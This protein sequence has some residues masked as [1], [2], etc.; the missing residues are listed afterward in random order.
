MCVGLRNRKSGQGP[1]EFRARERERER[2][3]KKENNI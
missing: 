2:E 3:R 1:K